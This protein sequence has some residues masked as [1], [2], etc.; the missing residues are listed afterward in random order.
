MKS[1]ALMAI[2]AVNAYGVML[3]DEVSDAEIADAVHELT[4]GDYSLESNEAIDAIHD[5]IDAAE[6]AEHTADEIKE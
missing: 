5:A 6:G 2:M 4:D 1:F 3:L